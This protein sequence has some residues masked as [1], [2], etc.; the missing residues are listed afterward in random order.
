M[1]IA[2][3]IA[4]R[5]EQRDASRARTIPPTDVS[6]IPSSK[7]VR[8]RRKNTRRTGTTATSSS[9]SSTAL[10]LVPIER[11]DLETERA[12]RR[13]RCGRCGPAR[14]PRCA[15]SEALDR[16]ATALLRP[17]RP[18]VVDARPRP[19]SAHRGWDVVTA[20]H[21]D[22]GITP[23]TPACGWDGDPVDQDWVMDALG[24]MDNHASK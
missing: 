12:R 4:A 19:A 6:Q 20:A 5:R 2:T 21:R 8:A 13:G 1:R 22:P 17:A 10:V 18:R 7:I 14:I 11:E 23:G 24:S 9:R 15:T 3:H 16:D